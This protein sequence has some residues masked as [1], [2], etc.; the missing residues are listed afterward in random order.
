VGPLAAL[1]GGI[2]TLL[3][4]QNPAQ[5]T[6]AV[7]VRWQFMRNADVKLQWDHVSLPAGATGNFLAAQPGFAGSTVNVYSAAVDFVF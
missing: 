3:A 5:N 6:V 4:G 2:N 1:A 7:G